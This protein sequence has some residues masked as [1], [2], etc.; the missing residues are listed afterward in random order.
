[1]KTL[2]VNLEDRSYPIYIG[3]ELLQNPQIFA[4]HINAS[5]VMLVSNTTVA[6]LYINKILSS[7]EKY[8]LSQ[9]IL[10]DGEQY[11]SLETLNQIFD[12]LIENKH[13]RTTTIIALGG[14]VIGDMAGF[15]AACY[16]RGVNFIQVPTSLLAQ[17][18]ASVGGKT[19]VNHPLGKNMIGAFHQPQAVIID[20]D[21][22]K[23]LPE[24]EF[25]AGMAEVIKHALIHDAEFL[26]YLEANMTAI[27]KHEPT[28][29]QEVVSK[30]CAIKAE[31]VSQDE[32]EQG[33][34]ALL[35]FGHTLGHA[36]ESGLGYGK[37][38]HGEAV[39]IGMLFAAD[40]SCQLGYLNQQ[41]LIRIR[42]LLQ[43]AN[44]P[45]KIPQE[46]S[47]EKY[48]DLMAVDKKVQAG[49]LRFIVL[50]KL[51]KSVILDTISDNM[52]KHAIRNCS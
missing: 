43:A 21:T 3:S 12:S 30:C 29:L 27:Q 51:G 42:N 49:K 37:Y 48:L 41:D 24:R 8:Q 22:L 35:N 46:L 52:V 11:K 16:Q 38:L 13:H 2:V 20:L 10:P 1:M 45:T 31:I 9:V 18:D 7:L 50:E 40:L 32:T 28:A 39:A 15:A 44:L 14:G 5:Q 17:V 6:P 36:I 47:V 34:R 23:T 25:N 33:K 26:T 4:E 19:A